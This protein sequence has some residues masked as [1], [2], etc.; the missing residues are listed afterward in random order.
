MLRRLH[1]DQR[2]KFNIVHAVLLIAFAAGAYATVMYYPPY[3]QYWKI[4]SKARQMALTAST[5]QMNDEKNKNYF[6]GEMRSIGVEY[7]TSRDITYH[8]YN[9]EK[10]QVAFEY[11][12]PVKHLFMSQ[13]HVLHFRVLCLAQAGMCVESD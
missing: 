5:T 6:D 3:V 10:V 11:E 1:R 8:R 9:P 2:G 13:P 4:R 7:P 12:Y